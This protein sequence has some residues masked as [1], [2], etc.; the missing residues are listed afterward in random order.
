MTKF[1]EYKE[2]LECK[3]LFIPETH[4]Q[5]YCQ[6]PCTFHSMKIKNENAKWLKE[7][8][9]EKPRK[10]QDENRVAYGFFRKK[11]AISKVYNACRG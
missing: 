4:F 5:K 6:S 9:P 1:K 11:Y 10:R 8:Q 7:K 3:K 2:C